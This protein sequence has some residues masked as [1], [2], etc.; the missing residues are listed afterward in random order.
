MGNILLSVA[1]VTRNRPHSLEQ[2]LMSWHQQTIAPFE[3]IV[4][5]DSQGD[6]ENE[7][8][9]LATRFGCIYTSGPGRG[10]YSNR[11]H[12]ALTCRGSHI[13]TADDDHTH[14]SDYVEKV[15]EVIASDPDRIWIFAEKS[16]K[17]EN[18]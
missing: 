4:S 10:L 8:R 9:Q 16:K 3:I 17:K 12:A 2:C 1:L 6:Y 11:N 13:L 7:V 14:P 18:N 5:D 15:L